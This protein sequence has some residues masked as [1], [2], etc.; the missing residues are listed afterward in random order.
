VLSLKAG[1]TT[2]GRLEDSD[3]RI[4]HASVSGRHATIE[5]FGETWTIKVNAGLMSSLVCTISLNYLM[6]DW[7]FFLRQSIIFHFLANAGWV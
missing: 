6:L 7:A 4:D 3:L 2:V 1:P 5:K